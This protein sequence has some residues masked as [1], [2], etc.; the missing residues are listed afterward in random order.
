M[1]YPVTVLD[2][3]NAANLARIASALERIAKVME[4]AAK[5]VTEA[6]EIKEERGAARRRRGRLTRR[7]AIRPCWGVSCRGRSVRSFGSA[8][9]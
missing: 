2:Q 4:D 7:S 3:K 1:G 9:A 6:K 5:E 8:S